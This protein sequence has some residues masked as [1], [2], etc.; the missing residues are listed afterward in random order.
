[1]SFSAL[2]QIGPRIS[3]QILGS[4]YAQYRP[5]GASNPIQAG[6]LLGNIPAWITADARGNGDRPFAP[7]KPTAYAMVDPALTQ[8]GDYLIGPLGTFFIASQDVPMPIQAV[9][10][11]YTITVAR[12]GSGAPSTGYYYGG[13][14]SVDVSPILTAWPASVIQGTK[15]EGGEIKLPGDTRLAWVAILMPSVGG[16]EI[17]PGDW[18]TDSEGTPMQYTVSSRELTPLG[19]RLSASTAVA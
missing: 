5:S 1:L 7:A 8:V 16:V 3:G 11:N 12:P 15:G 4:P 10:C 18:I 2:F 13:V 6:N 17:L 19:W 9:R 14:I